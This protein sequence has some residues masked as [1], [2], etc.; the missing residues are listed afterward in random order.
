[1][2]GETPTPTRKTC[3]VTEMT[4][5]SPSLPSSATVVVADERQSTRTHSTTGEG[6][7]DT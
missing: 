4:P 3:A 2:A 6:K 7:P 1:M 5:P